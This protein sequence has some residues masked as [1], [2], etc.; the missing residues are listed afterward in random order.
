MRRDPAHDAGECPRR[1]ERH[2]RHNWIQIPARRR[3]IRDENQER[4]RK[5]EK[6]DR[7]TGCHRQ[8]PESA[9]RGEQCDWPAHRIEPQHLDVASRRSERSRVDGAINHNLAIGGDI[10]DGRHWFGEEKRRQGDEDQ[11]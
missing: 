1:E 10:A 5:G 7:S 2:E 11:D 6:E 8:H 3:S 4:D 9:E